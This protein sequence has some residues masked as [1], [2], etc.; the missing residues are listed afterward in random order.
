MLKNT[1]QKSSQNLLKSLKS[2]I[3]SLN[4][5]QS[6][7]ST[8]WNVFN[9]HLI[10]GHPDKSPQGQIIHDAIILSDEIPGTFAKAIEL[11]DKRQIK[12]S[13][14]TLILD[15]CN[16]S[17]L[18]IICISSVCGD[19]RFYDYSTMGKCNLRLYIRCFPSPV[20]AIHFYCST[21]SSKEL[22]LIFGDMAGTVRVIDFMKSFKFRH[23]SVMRQFSYQELMK[24]TMIDVRNV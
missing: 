12:K 7:N 8:R 9:D 6:F 18:Q 11:S 4:L 5:W 1:F 22:K 19:L 21:D 23:G 15:A 3:I 10:Y 2:S 17:D 20:V 16:L 24:V 14:R 13:P